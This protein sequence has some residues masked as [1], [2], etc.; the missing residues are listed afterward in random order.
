MKLAPGERSILASFSSGPAAESA[1]EELRQSGYGE[2]QLDR[3]G[4]F[5]FDPGANR[6]IP[7]FGDESS[8]VSATLWDHGRMLDEDTRVLLGA[9]PENSGMAGAPVD[10]TPPF[11]ITV[12]T[13]DDRVQRAVGILQRHGGRV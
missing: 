7:V 10:L 13:S 11:L 1:L 6:S 12:V 4:G 5:G 3:V 2:V 8:Q 9:T